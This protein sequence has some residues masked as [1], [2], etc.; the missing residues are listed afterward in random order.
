MP[1]LTP[2]L[3]WPWWPIG[4]TIVPVSCTVVSFSSLV[5]PV[6]GR[7]DLGDLG[8]EVGQVLGAAWPAGDVPAARDALAGLGQQVLPAHR[9]FDVA[10]PHLAV[11]ERQ[12]VLRRRPSAS[13]ASSSRLRL[14][15][16]AA[17]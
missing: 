9:F 10:A 4:L 16:C 7:P 13:A 12:Q 15:S 2:P 3:I 17:S 1:W 6:S 14:A 5:S 8:D 11:A